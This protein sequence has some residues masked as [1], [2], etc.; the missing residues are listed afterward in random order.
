MRRLALLALAMLLATLAAQADD[1]PQP[2]PVVQPRPLESFAELL[3][4][5]LFSNTRRPARFS[6]ETGQSLDEK[7]LRETWRLTGIVLRDERQLALFKQRQGDQRE[8]LEVGMALED[9]WLLERIDSDH[10]L[11]MRNQTA[12]QML[13]REP[14]GSSDAPP[15]AADAPAAPRAAPAAPAEAAPTATDSNGEPVPEQG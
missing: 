10:V 12:V 13:L 9:E 7:Q 5:P 14:G 8:E 3:E 1:E 6:A 11:L 4:R 15:P 2:A